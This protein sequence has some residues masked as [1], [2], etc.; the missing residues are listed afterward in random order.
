[1]P[2]STTVT[3]GGR[4]RFRRGGRRFRKKG[5]VPKKI[6]EYVRKTIVKESELKYIFNFNPG[7]TAAPLRPDTSYPAA[8]GE[9][10]NRM[11]QGSAGTQRI[12]DRIKVRRIQIWFKID[13]V[14]DP[15]LVRLMLVRD[16]KPN[17]AHP[18]SALLFESSN[19]ADTNPVYA[20]LNEDQ[21]PSRF[22]VL[23]DQVYKV[24]VFGGATDR[25][26]KI[27]GY[28]D[29]RIK[30]PK[31]TIY[32]GN[33]GTIADILE[34]AYHLIW[35][36]DWVAGAGSRPNLFYNARLHFEDI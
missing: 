2:T 32:S 35:F 13:A 22:H 21:T 10:L 28:W 11:Q 19:L 17:G 6:R 8:P 25:A 20:V 15:A 36:S 18:T 34:N 14:T 9:V 5:K 16:L 7:G 1:M 30:N 12:G 26:E 23:R 31:P 3:S 33:A 27:V 29:V 4:R 24:N